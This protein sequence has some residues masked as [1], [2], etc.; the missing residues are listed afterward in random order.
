MPLLREECWLLACKQVCA[1]RLKRHSVTAQTL[2]RWEGEFVRYVQEGLQHA[3]VDKLG[4]SCGSC[5]ETAGRKAAMV[6]NRAEDRTVLVTGDLRW[7][8]L[9]RRFGWLENGVCCVLRGMRR[10]FDN[11]V[12]HGV[13]VCGDVVE[14]LHATTV[15]RSSSGNKEEWVGW[16]VG[17]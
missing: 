13:C 11:M 1:C 2:R 6:V 3:A 8:P 7:C 10:L 15:S 14:M 12:M 17:W 4:A 5:S 9:E 16:L